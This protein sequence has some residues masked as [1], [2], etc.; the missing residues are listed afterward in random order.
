MTDNLT[1]GVFT[2]NI[3]ENI[4]EQKFSEIKQ[5]IL[6]ENTT[7]P[8]ILVFG[9]QEVPISLL[10][11]KH[12]ERHYLRL[13]GTLLEK[14]FDSYQLSS[15]LNKSG[16]NVIN[17]KKDNYTESIHD[18]SRAIKGIR[19]S[20]ISACK[21]KTSS[22]EG[23]GI[24]LYILH[25]KNCRVQGI[26]PVISKYLSDCPPN[27]KGGIA[28][29]GTKGYVAI[30]LDL[31][32]KPKTS[33]DFITT[34]MPFKTAEK[35]NKFYNE[36]KYWLKQNKFNS[37]NQIIFGDVNT[38]SLLTKDCY[39][40]AIIT[41]TKLDKESD[42]NYCK[43]K[44]KLEKLS[45]SDSINDI[46]SSFIG[47]QSCNVSSDCRL[48]ESDIETIQKSDNLVKLLIDKDFIG[49]PPN[50]QAFY[51]FKEHPIKFFPTYKRDKKT[52]QFSLKKEKEGRLPGYA[53]RI[54]YKGN[55]IPTKYTSLNIIGNDHLPV[56]KA[57]KLTHSTK[58]KAATKAIL[59]SNKS[60]KKCQK[61]PLEKCG[62]EPYS[63]CRNKLDS[64]TNKRIC[65]KK[66]KTSSKVTTL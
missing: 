52:G 51:G 38:R 54:F 13:I 44:N 5:Q 57:F 22:K 64:K 28:F 59:V 19:T 53:D 39:K 24:I 62:I 63:H 65:K 30:T 15:L 4:N 46:G 18:S 21:N 41:C 36:I 12:N 26:K 33:I 43:V 3:G 50:C 35:S 25:K 17:N 45:R 9:F 23:F 49:N 48:S 6:K 34:H 32:I 20:S 8:D 42:A 31:G 56:F 14:N 11:I 27:K 60:S 1:L 40:K 16:L 10:G 7:L 66:K 37:T 58:L 61:A 29:G 55:M 2:W 47:T